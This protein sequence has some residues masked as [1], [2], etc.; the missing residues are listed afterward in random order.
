VLVQKD[1]STCRLQSADLLV[2]EVDVAIFGN[3]ARHPDTIEK[4]PSQFSKF[5]SVEKTWSA[6]LPLSHGVD[7]VRSEKAL[8]D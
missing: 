2:G 6:L 7:Y 3:I 1:L 8:L 5:P 4:P